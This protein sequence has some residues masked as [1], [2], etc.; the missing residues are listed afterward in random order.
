MKVTQ[1]RPFNLRLG[2]LIGTT[3]LI[4]LLQIAALFPRITTPIERIE[5]SARDLLMRMRGTREPSTDIVIVAI[6]DFSF[7]WTGYQWPWPR[8]YLAEI[9][10]QVNAAGGKVVGVDIFLFEPDKD[11]ANDEMF[12][13][14]LGQSPAAVSVV[15]I[16]HDTQRGFAIST[17]SQPLSPYMQSLDGVGVTTFTRDEDAIVRTVRAFD[18]YN[19]E[20]YYHWAF[21]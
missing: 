21:E 13:R 4:L 12:A 5:F 19:N 15:Q 9:V 3:A 16:T 10:D 20:P 14:S 17:I 8:S 7:N 11:P 18:S 6:D 1:K 2:L